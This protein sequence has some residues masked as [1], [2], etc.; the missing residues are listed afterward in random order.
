MHFKTVAFALAL[1]SSPALACN[2]DC[3]DLDTSGRASFLSQMHARNQSM[4]D[5]IET[6]TPV[7]RYEIKDF[8]LTTDE[9][10]HLQWGLRRMLD[11]Q[12]YDATFGDAPR[13]VTVAV[14]ERSIGEAGHPD[15]VGTFLP[16]WDFADDDSDPYDPSNPN[17]HGQCV[18]SMLAAPHNGIGLAGA[19]HRAR[20]LPI[21]ADFWSLHEAIEYASEN[22]DVIQ[23]SGGNLGSGNPSGEPMFPFGQAAITAPFKT[24]RKIN[25]PEI[26]AQLTNI[27]LAIE[28]SEI[29]I[30][31]GESNRLMMNSPNF[32]A[33]RPEVIV[34]GPV[35]IH[36]EI[37]GNSTY[38]FRFD[39]LAPGGSRADHPFPS[40][41][42]SLF[43]ST[44]FPDRLRVVHRTS[45]YDDIL[46]AWGRGYSFLT[47]G[48]SAVPYVT[49]AVAAIRSYRPDLTTEEIRR[50]LKTSGNPV[51]PTD[52][53][54]DATADI[55]SYRLMMNQIRAGLA[56]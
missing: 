5:S 28:A 55:L 19:F 9:Y 23:L 25:T 21:R 43:R 31:T 38:S 32:L 22:A 50:I 18:A 30:V 6:R 14:I 51:T 26:M 40:S 54:M 45:D 8:P 36:D 46:C 44:A 39:V 34:A 15:L 53:L 7:T 56:G 29:P 47:L 17:M 1:F 12:S 37:P 24:L 41:V 11:G 3:M 2:V 10:S 33:M 48:S 20:V 52:N 4:V 16:G 49:A 27:R 42:T 13:D 35:N